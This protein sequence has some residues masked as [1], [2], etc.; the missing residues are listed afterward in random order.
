MN[1]PGGEKLRERHGSQGWMGAAASEVFGL[2]IESF[3]LCEILGAQAGEF[4]QALLQC[5]V[6]RLFEL[7][8]AVEGIKGSS[9][10][11]LKDDAE[12]R[13]PVG[14]LSGNEMAHDVV[15]A[16]GVFPFVVSD[17]DIGQATQQRVEGCGSASQKGGG[18]GEAEFS[19]GWHVLVDASGAGWTQGMEGT[20]LRDKPKKVLRMRPL[21]ISLSLGGRS[22]EGWPEFMLR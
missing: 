17:P 20:R 8:E 2:Q 5:V 3:E 10:A 13:H 4:I 19:R 12:A 14:A 6:L 7:R 18:L 15:G 22:R 21:R 1:G 9:F 16:P 11:V